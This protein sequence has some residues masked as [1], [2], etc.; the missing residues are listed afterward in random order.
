VIRKQGK[1]SQPNKTGVN[2]IMKAMGEVISIPKNSLTLQVLSS[3]FTLDSGAL[4]QASVLFPDAILSSSRHI[5]LEVC[6]PGFLDIPSPGP[7][8]FLFLVC[9]RQIPFSHSLFLAIPGFELKASHLV[10]RCS[11]T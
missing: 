6:V 1:K 11:T 4:Y 2:F 3:F 7:S 9:I 10:G 5:P 8:V